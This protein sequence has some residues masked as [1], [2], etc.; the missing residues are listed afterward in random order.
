METSGL[1]RLHDS[2]RT[3]KPLPM[4]FFASAIE[5]T[6]CTEDRHSAC[7]YFPAAVFF[8]VHRIAQSLPSEC[9]EDGLD[10]LPSSA[11]SNTNTP[12]GLS[13]PCTRRNN[14]SS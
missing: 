6:D 2:R 14:P 10:T 1:E 5:T 3:I 4:H 9:S 8:F 11:M 7:Q 13:A 12:S